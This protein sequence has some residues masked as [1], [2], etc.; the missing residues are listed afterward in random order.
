M[1]SPLAPH[2]LERTAE[3][4]NFKGLVGGVD[5]VRS[6]RAAA[7]KQQF[8]QGGRLLLLDSC[9]TYGEVLRVSVPQF[10]CF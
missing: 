1:G 3:S 8:L 5:A 2:H 10:S 4:V 6:C 7:C 9:V